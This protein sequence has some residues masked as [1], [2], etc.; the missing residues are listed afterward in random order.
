MNKEKMNMIKVTQEHKMRM[1]KRFFCWI[2]W[3]S[4][5]VGYDDIHPRGLDPLKFLRFATCKWCGFMG[6]IDSQGNLF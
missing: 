5:L 4:Y 2:G 3:H 1:I 6:Q